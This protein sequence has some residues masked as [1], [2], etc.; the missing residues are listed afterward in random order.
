MKNGHNG[1]RER[2]KLLSGGYVLGIRSQPARSDATSERDAFQ[3]ARFA[4]RTNPQSSLTAGKVI[5]S[6]EGDKFIC[7]DNGRTNLFKSF[8]LIKLEHNLA[9]KR[10][11]KVIDPVS[12]MDKASSETDLGPIWAAVE[13]MT[14]DND[15]IRVPKPVYRLIT[16]ET[17]QAGDKIGQYMVKRVDLLLGVYVAEVS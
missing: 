8:K 3:A 13:P 1:M 11:V 14:E 4:F 15:M 2:F 5:V 7:V 6:P 10:V 12:K 9:W 16:G 17:I